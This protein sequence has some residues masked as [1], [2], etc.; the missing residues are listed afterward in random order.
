MARFSFTGNAERAPSMEE[1]VGLRK[2]WIPAPRLPHHH[3]SILGVG[4]LQPTGQIGPADLFVNK[5]LLEYS[6]VHLFPY[7]LW[8]LFAIMAELSSYNRYQIAPKAQD[9]YCLALYIQS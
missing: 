8:L 3:W 5:V 2:K 6:Q 4:K 7:G 1:S 9:I